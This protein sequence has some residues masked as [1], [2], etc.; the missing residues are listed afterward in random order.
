MP[1]IIEADDFNPKRIYDKLIKGCM[2]AKLWEIKCWVDEGFIVYKPVP[3][4]IIIEDGYYIIKVVSN[5]KKN[6]MKIIS[7]YIPVIKFID[8]ADNT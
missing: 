6:A 2:E 3:F 5:S 4:Q 8:D 1:N 7:D